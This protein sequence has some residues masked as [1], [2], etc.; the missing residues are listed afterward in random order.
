M[1]G[2]NTV[3]PQSPL[4]KPEYRDAW[5]NYDPKAANKLLDEMGLT[6]RDGDGIRL[7]PDGRPLEIIVETAG[8]S[9]EQTDVLELIR[10]SWREVGI[11]LFTKPSQRDVLRNRVF[12]GDTHDVGLDRA[13][14]R[15]G[16]G[17]TCS[18]TEFA[19]TSQQQLQ[20]PKWGQYVET[21]G[22][23]GEA[24]DM[25]EAEELMEL[26]LDWR[27][28]ASDGGARRD[29][30]QDARDPCRPGLH[31]RHRRRRAAAGGG[32][33]QAAERAGGRHLQLGSRRV[34]RHLP[35]RHVLAGAG[36]TNEAAAP[37][38]HG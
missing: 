28:T 23:A 13:R 29:L 25:P 14:E 37:Q 6:K 3:L 1:E 30:G 33:Q 5:A 35:P 11:K 17:R 15:P 19:P 32:R 18:P 7:L 9:T 4:Y 16:H 8:E 2:S 31:H 34:L 36:G 21:S 27:T 20:W 38:T 10:D 22:K 24:I 12:A 26:Y